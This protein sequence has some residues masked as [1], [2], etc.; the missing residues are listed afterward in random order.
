[1][2]IKQ[3]IKTKT[4]GTKFREDDEEFEIGWCSVCGGPIFL[5][6]EDSIVQNE[7]AYS[8]IDEGEKVEVKESAESKTVYIDVNVDG[9]IIISKEKHEIVDDIDGPRLLVYKGVKLVK[10]VP[11]EYDE[12]IIGRYSMS[13]EPDIDLS[14]YDREKVTSRKHVLVYK[15]NNE[16]IARNLSAKNSLHVNKKAI[17]YGEDYKLQHE[18]I[19]IL[20]RKFAIEFRD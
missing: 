18:D 6:E 19:L 8:S 3:C 2:Q 16:F 15:I 4:C 7:V 12:T 11:I 5:I 9:E 1:M 20:S 17:A 14:A 13:S 10:I